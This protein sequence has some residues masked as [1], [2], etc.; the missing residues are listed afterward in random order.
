M[1]ELLVWN[2]NAV[3]RFD[4]H[5]LSAGKEQAAVFEKAGLKG[6]KIIESPSDE[7]IEILCRKKRII[8]K[9]S[10]YRTFSGWTVLLQN[11]QPMK[12]ILLDEKEQRIFGRKEIPAPGISMQHFLLEKKEDGWWIED[13]NSANGTYLNGKRIKRQSVEPGDWVFAAGQS[14]CFLKH[15]LLIPSADSTWKPDFCQIRHPAAPDRD[16]V[17]IRSIEPQE[18]ALEGPAYSTAAPAPGLFSAAGPAIMIL[19]SSLAS[20]AGVMIRRD[21][22]FSAAMILSAALMAGA[23]GVYGMLNRHLQIRERKDRERKDRLAYSAYLKEQQQKAQK[24]MEKQS[25]LWKAQK[26][27]LFSL[28]PSLMHQQSRTDSWFLP[29]SAGSAPSVKFRLPSLGYQQSSRSEVQALEKLAGFQFCSPVWKGIEKGK[30][31]ILYLQNE[32]DLEWIYDLWCWLIYR[33]DRK[34]AWIG[35]EGPPSWHPASLLEG[36]PMVFET[37]NDWR[38][39]TALHPEIEWTVCAKTAPDFQSRK[40]L[41]ERGTWI[42]II[43][44]KEKQDA[45]NSQTAEI[46]IPV[47]P[48][49]AGPARCRP[50]CFFETEDTAPKEQDWRIEV[51]EHGCTFHPHADLLVHPGPGVCWD[52]EE[53]GPHV[54]AAGM[55]GSGKSEGILT[56]LFELA[57]HNT[58]QQ[59][60]FIVV[61]FKGGAFAKPL[62]DLP[63]LAGVVTNL[64]GSSVFR[65]IAAIEEELVIR[66]KKIEKWLC[67]HPEETGDLKSYNTFHRSDPISHL[68]VVVDEFAQLKS[69]YPESMKQLQEAARIGRSLGMHLILSTQKPA[70]VVDDQIWAN[71]RSRIC[72]QVESGADSREMISTSQAAC[73]KEPGEFILQ[74][75]SRP[76][77]KS[78]AYFLRQSAPGSLRTWTEDEEGNLL[79]VSPPACSIL[80]ILQKK[81]GEKWESPADGMKNEKNRRWILY[82]DP[83]ADPASLN[84]PAEDGISYIRPWKIADGQNLLLSGTAEELVKAAEALSIC[85]LKPVYTWNLFLESAD[86]ELE[87]P[88]LWLLADSEQQALVIVQTD[89]SFPPDLLELLAENR[90][91][92]LI[93]L[94]SRQDRLITR[95]RGLFDMAGAM[96]ITNREMKY[97][98]F[99]GTMVDEAAW[100]VVHLLHERKISRIILP[101]PQSS[102]MRFAERKK[103]KIILPSSV[104][105]LEAACRLPYGFCGLEK[106]T[107]KPVFR[108]TNKSLCLAYSSLAGQITALKLAAFWHAQDPMLSIASW[109]VKGEVTLCDV[110]SMSAMSDPAWKEL[111]AQSDLLYAGTDFLSFQYQLGIRGIVT[112]S[113]NGV[114]SS[115]AQTADLDLLD[116]EDLKINRQDNSE[117]LLQESMTAAGIN[118]KPLSAA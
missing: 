15:E 17:L 92:T 41:P 65:M 50:S 25:G 96:T 4:L 32:G 77:Q 28:D 26:E 46:L 27:K 100:P 93:A 34:F 66:Q 47:C 87:I 42:R 33:P 95:R 18:F 72:F 53:D 113:G 52:L 82:P 48:K 36:R 73:L 112:G 35:F 51:I 85:A 9:P 39:W 81:A 1:H 109:P 80:E 12:P 16:F 104:M 90:K 114:F 2:L 118:H 45:E 102:R 78:R 69:R 98:L 62:E 11:L 31:S 8:L 110:S 76:L 94:C 13:L 29:V 44:E 83:A 84:E 79:A 71:T 70:G 89:E 101:D 107:G 54:L 19:L 115:G 22:G 3:H 49:K 30:E 97:L 61:D 68:F 37:E 14:L 63:H 105:K 10:E 64:E 23:F 56:V 6:W 20:A 43:D 103:Q 55:T 86:Q 38:L 116:I 88:S 106:D 7:Q 59:V 111:L 75:G 117:R 24:M 57:V 91:I 67:A 58:P 40:L 60:Q 21:G 99:D 74:A 5:A 108:K